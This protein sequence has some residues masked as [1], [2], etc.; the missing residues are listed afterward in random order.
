MALFA[1]GQF[2]SL[3]VNFL[4]VN[5]ASFSEIGKFRFNQQFTSFSAHFLLFSLAGQLAHFCKSEIF[6]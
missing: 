1:G 5:S 6:D 3:E 2:F 4:G